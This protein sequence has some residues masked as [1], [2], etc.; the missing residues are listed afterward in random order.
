M[1]KLNFFSCKTLFT[2]H[3][4]SVEVWINFVADY[5]LELFNIVLKQ[6]IC[7]MFGID[8]EKKS[9]HL[10]SHGGLCD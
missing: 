1:K 9:I 6:I 2:H 8:S 10:L 7:G 3:I 5:P 4:S